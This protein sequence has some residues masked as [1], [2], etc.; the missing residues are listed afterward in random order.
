MVT[1]EHTYRAH[2]TLHIENDDGSSFPSGWSTRKSE[3]AAKDE[4]FSFKPGKNLIKGWTEGVLLMKEG[5][6]AKLH[7][8]AIKGYGGSPVG[9]KGGAFYI[10]AN[11]DLMFDIE[12]LGKQ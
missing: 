6:R 4:P 9:S 2:V 7:I 12:I 10:P 5:E 8:P 11:S 1:K 3:G